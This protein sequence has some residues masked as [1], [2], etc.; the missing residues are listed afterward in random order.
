M[1]VVGRYVG[2]HNNNYHC[3]KR[4]SFLCDLLAILEDMGIRV[5]L[6]GPGWDGCEYPLPSAVQ[7]IDCSHP[8]YGAVYRSSRLVISVAAQ[9]GGQYLFWRAL[10][11]AA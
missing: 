6:L 5:A 10:R 8:A 4:F 7:Q 9:E 3:R 1:L 2:S 11:V